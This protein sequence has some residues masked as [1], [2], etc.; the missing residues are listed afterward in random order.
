MRSSTLYLRDPFREV[1]TLLKAFAPQPV[2]QPA[3]YAPVADGY[4]DG[5]DAVIK[6]DLPGVAIEDVDVEVVSGRLVVSG[7]RRDQRAEETEG[8]RFRE[9]RYGAFKRSFRLGSQVSADR[10]S[11]SYDAGVLTVRVADAYAKPAGQKIEIS[12]G[13][14]E[15]EASGTPDE[16]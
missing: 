15:L 5:E 7:E 3:G 16:S 10:V 2:V 4:R 13:T 12:A 1:D 9:V 11:A 8:R 6:L 14:P